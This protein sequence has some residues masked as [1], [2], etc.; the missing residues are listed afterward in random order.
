MPGRDFWG[1]GCETLL[2]LVVTASAVLLLISWISKEMTQG[3]RLFVFHWCLIW[4]AFA[5]FFQELKLV[6]FACNT[7]G[8]CVLM[9]SWAGCFLSRCKSILF[10]RIVQNFYFKYLNLLQLLFNIKC[11]SYVQPWSVNSVTD[12]FL[13][14]GFR[15]IVPHQWEGG[16]V[17]HG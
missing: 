7:E 17:A 16:K 3:G 6:H 12:S 4:H 10:D 9:T 14:T 15:W 11:I 5:H 2:K 13:W 1:W 8:L